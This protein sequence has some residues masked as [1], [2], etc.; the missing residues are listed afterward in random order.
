MILFSGWATGSAIARI[1]FYFLGGGFL[2]EPLST[3]KTKQINATCLAIRELRSSASMAAS[4]H[5]CMLSSHR[6]VLLPYLPRWLFLTSLHLFLF[7]PDGVCPEACVWGKPA[8]LVSLL[9]LVES[10]LSEGIRM[11]HLRR[12]AWTHHFHWLLCEGWSALNNEQY[13]SRWELTYGQ[14]ITRPLTLKWGGGKCIWVW[15]WKMPFRVM[16]ILY[17]HD[18]FIKCQF[19]SVLLTLMPYF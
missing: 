13:C 17:W 4:Y 7:G 19:W 6:L 14:F 11:T 8:L 9:S 1:F 3:K 15:S 18:F 12:V 5:A 16:T 10:G 2:C